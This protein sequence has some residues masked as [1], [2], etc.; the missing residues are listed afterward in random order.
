LDPFQS[1]QRESTVPFGG[2][3]VFLKKDVDIDRTVALFSGYF[4]D[5]P[6]EIQYYDEACIQNTSLSDDY[7]RACKKYSLGLPSYKTLIDYPPEL[8]EPGTFHPTMA[9][10]VD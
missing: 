2:Q 10:K 7:R 5:H 4:F 6:E 3:G 1:F 8:D 9:Q